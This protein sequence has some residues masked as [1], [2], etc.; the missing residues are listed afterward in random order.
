MESCLQVFILK[1]SPMKT[2]VFQTSLINMTDLYNIL[3][4]KK[5]KSFCAE[6]L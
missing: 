1:F 5:S 2:F 4:R 3:V 6:D